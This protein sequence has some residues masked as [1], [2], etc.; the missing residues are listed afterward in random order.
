L[1]SVEFYQ[2]ITPLL[3]RRGWVVV[4]LVDGPGQRFAKSQWATLSSLWGFVGVVGEAG[5][6]R[7]RRFGNLVTLASPE[8]S[9]PA[10]WPELVRRGPH[11]SAQLS[12][13]KLSRLMSGVDVVR[14]DTATP[15]PRLGGGFLPSS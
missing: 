14:D 1:T 4:N 2:A 5:V 12:G 6:V 13:S 15:S 8:P 9:E 3:G 10:W 11:P 7:G